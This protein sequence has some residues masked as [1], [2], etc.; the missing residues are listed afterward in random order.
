[1]NLTKT[2]CGLRTVN[3]M[4]WFETMSGFLP[5]LLSLHMSLDIPKCRVLLLLQ[6]K[7][8]LQVLVFSSKPRSYGNSMFKLLRN[9]QSVFQS[10][11]H[12]TFPPAM[13][14]GSY[15]SKSSPAVVLSIL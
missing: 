5:T 15:L 9:W 1:M 8:F 6:V 7:S 10:G 13:H 11:C 4:L 14:K 2:Y 3:L 12:L